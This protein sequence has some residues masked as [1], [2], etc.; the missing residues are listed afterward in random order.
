MDN[1]REG[2]NWFKPQLGAAS[3]PSGLSIEV[4]GTPQQ[5]RFQL[6]LQRHENPLQDPSSRRKKYAHVAEKI[7]K[8]SERMVF[9]SRMP[10]NTPS[11]GWLST[12]GLLLS[13]D[14][15]DTTFKNYLKSSR[16]RRHCKLSVAILAIVGIAMNIVQLDNI[17]QNKNTD[18]HVN[19]IG[20]ETQRETLQKGPFRGSKQERGDSFIHPTPLDFYQ[21]PSRPPSPGL[22]ISGQSHSSFS[23]NHEESG[24]ETEIIKQNGGYIT[25]S[26]QIVNDSFPDFDPSQKFIV[27]DGEQVVSDEVETEETPKRIEDDIASQPE[28]ITK[29]EGGPDGSEEGIEI[30]SIQSQS[31]F[32]IDDHP[33]KDARTDTQLDDIQSTGDMSNHIQENDSITGL[34]SSAPKDALDLDGFFF[35]EFPIFDQAPIEDVPTQET[36]PTQHYSEF[37]SDF[38]NEPERAIPPGVTQPTLPG[39]E[40]LPKVNADGSIPLEEL[41]NFKDST[42]PWDS[43]E[44]PIFLHIPKAGGST[45]KDIMGTCHRFVMATETGILDGHV[46]DEVS[47]NLTFLFTNVR[48]N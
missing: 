19:I 43:N 23:D 14:D 16:C 40:G 24:S 29:L 11:E 47:H 8:D 33:S 34:D 31:S 38:M 10:K 44:V 13:A 4:P 6:R 42:D 5:Q 15:E 39:L 30:D 9:K 46:D 48:S 3:N 32:P 18:D 28:S 7:L 41:V 26:G 22:P 25:D 37:K 45:V 36:F 17:L 1:T 21:G 20:V 2:F 27:Q 35:D 12:C